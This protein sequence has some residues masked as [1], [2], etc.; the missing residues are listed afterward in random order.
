MSQK[1]NN[2]TPCVEN[3]MEI[4]KGLY[5]H[6][7]S[8]KKVEHLLLAFGNNNGHVQ[9]IN[10]FNTRCTITGIKPITAQDV[11][12]IKSESL[13][14]KVAEFLLN[15]AVARD[16]DVLAFI[17]QYGW[18]S[19]DTSYTTQQHASLSSK[20]LVT[21]AAY[22]AIQKYQDELNT[23]YAEQKKQQQ[24]VKAIVFANTTEQVNIFDLAKEEK[25]KVARKPRKPVVTVE[26]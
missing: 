16:T 18:S 10:R 13:R 7:E 25:P 14:R 11:A 21:R 24:E 6:Q 8:R 23:Y 20:S 5:A 9:R 3:A 4:L 17:A 15:N 22:I 12:N 1:T 26:E 2:I 19:N